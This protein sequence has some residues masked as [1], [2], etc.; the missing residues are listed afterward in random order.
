LRLWGKEGKRRG[1]MLPH[2]WLFPGRS[3]GDPIST[4]QINRAIH[5]ATEAA[6]S[7]KIFRFRPDFGGVTGVFTS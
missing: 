2:G 4:R 1:V 5:E 7:L 6:E 3:H